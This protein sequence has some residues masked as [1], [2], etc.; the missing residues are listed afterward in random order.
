MPH[1]CH[2]HVP[3]RMYGVN[4]EAVDNIEV[5]KISKTK[6]QRTDGIKFKF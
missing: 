4:Q 5:H 3:K 2:I 6:R 1:T